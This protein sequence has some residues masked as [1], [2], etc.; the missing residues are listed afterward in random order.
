MVSVCWHDAVLMYTQAGMS[1]L[2]RF[3]CVQIH[4]VKRPENC[5]KFLH[6]RRP[7]KRQAFV[8]VYDMSAGASRGHLYPTQA[9]SPGC[10]HGPGE[11]ALR[12]LHHPD[13]PN[14]GRN[15]PGRGQRHFKRLMPFRGLNENEHERHN[16][17]GGQG[18]FGN[19]RTPLRCKKAGKFRLQSDSDVARKSRL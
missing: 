2:S 11:G 3:C 7:R 1:V 8:T 16:V 15:A 14:H 5:L 12:R 13:A 19:L 6:N 4:K 17:C 18:G 10:P 9:P